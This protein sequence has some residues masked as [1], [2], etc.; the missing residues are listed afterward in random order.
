MEGTMTR[1]CGAALFLCIA[2]P[3]LADP[4][5]EV[6]NIMRE[7]ELKFMPNKVVQGASQAVI[8]GS[9]AP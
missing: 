7:P 9:P 4:P 5:T 2:G 6:M 1:I 8:W 3:T